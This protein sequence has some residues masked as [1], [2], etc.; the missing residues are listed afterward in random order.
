MC[1]T[2][3]ITNLHLC[4]IGKI[5]SQHNKKNMSNTIT[6]KET[7]SIKK[8]ERFAT[9]HWDGNLKTGKGTL[10]TESEILDETKYSFAT[11]FTDDNKGTN[12]EELFAAAHAGCFTMSVAALLSKKG[13][14]ATSL[15]TKATVTMEGLHITTIHLAIA[16]TVD[17][18]LAEDFSEITF[19][20]QKTCMISMILK[21][22]I[23]LE[24]TFI[25]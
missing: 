6:S 23:T 12:P 24:T 4:I 2:L 15:D 17:E 11:R 22:P 8:V 16:G 3:R 21:I 7:E 9:A 25:G 1:N 19:E 10:S 5:H 14:V 18:M 13:F 20:A